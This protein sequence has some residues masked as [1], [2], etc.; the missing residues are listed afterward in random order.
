[1]PDQNQHVDTGFL[2]SL[3]FNE[4]FEQ[5]SNHLLADAEPRV[6]L[7]AAELFTEYGTAISEDKL[8]TITGSLVTAVLQE[9]HDRIRARII[10]AL[11]ECGDDTIDD[12]VTA[13][14][15]SDRPTPADTPYPQFLLEWLGSHYSEFRLVAVAGLGDLG[16]SR[17]VPKL[18][19]ACSDR[20]P[21]V[22]RRAVIECGRVGDDRCVR[23]VAAHL[24]SDDDAVRRAAA[25]ALV[26]IG[27][28]K[29]LRALLPA[30]KSDDTVLRR[31][32]ITGLGSLGSL[33]VLGTLLRALNDEDAEVRRAAATAIIRLVAEAPSGESHTV[34]ETVARQLMTFPDR[35]V[36]AEFR[37]LFTD[38]E[39]PA[40]R[41]NTAW[42][43]GRI[44]GDDPQQDVILCLVRA[45]DDEDDRTAQVAA[46][47]LVRIGEPAI[48]DE[49][50]SFV[51]ATDL[52]SKA[53]SRADFIRN[54]LTDSEAEERLKDAVE[55][56]KVSDPIDYTRQKNAARD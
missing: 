5:L 49:L 26:S 36:V 7:R 28:E 19:N 46:S 54:Q 24:D 37:A 31:T 16:S 50:E 1:M 56:T 40:I 23:A 13:I 48:I 3:A 39:E 21:R 45:I 42:V 22:Q 38:T 27:S 35:D 15:D 34:R 55:Y 33:Q 20:D 18:A 11:L 25:T 32:A 14:A 53:L 51:S 47:S 12:L 41:R 10:E 8:E 2:D 17:V 29:A 30:A 44:A 9:P 6:R 52:G 4:Q 43:L